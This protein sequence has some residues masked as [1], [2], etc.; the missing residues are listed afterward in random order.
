MQYFG[1]HIDTLTSNNYC[2]LRPGDILNNK[3]QIINRLGR[4]KFSI[5]YKCLENATHKTYAVKVY[6]HGSDN[7]EYFDN[8]VSVFMKLWEDTLPCKY[9]LHGYEIFSHLMYDSKR[10]FSS[11]HP[12]IVFDLLGE[13]VYDLIKKLDSG[14]PIQDSKRL[15]LEV[16]HGLDFLHKRGIIHT[17]I[18]TENINLTIPIDQLNDNSQLSIVITDMGSA[19]P[20]DKLFSTK[21]GTKEFNSPELIFQQQY[22]TAADIWS[23]MCLCFELLTGDGLFNLD[24]GEDNEEG[25]E[26][27]DDGD[28]GEDEYIS[29]MSDTANSIGSSNESYSS[30]G[31]DEDDDDYFL[32]LELDHLVLIAQLLGNAPKS[33]SKNARNHYNTKGNIKG[34]P[35]IT[36]V[37]LNQLLVDNYGFSKKEA[38]QIE[39]FM[40]LG[41]KYVPSE[42]WTADKLIKHPF[43]SSI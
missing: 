26:D 35:K 40:F 23:F 9:L 16:L 8:E 5:V 43:L 12:C 27:D 39:E 20:S 7:R 42:R 34:N 3:Y 41:L 18:K 1:A 17:D 37:S 19:T 6:R 13:S 32:T 10:C 25:G 2:I 28:E 38:L 33:I 31:S 14:L 21:T 11:V 36:R 29:V 22:T 30:D 24:D 4:G 15:M